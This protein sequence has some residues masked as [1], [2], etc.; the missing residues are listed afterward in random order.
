MDKKV[1]VVDLDGTLY[2]TNTFHEFLFFLVKYFFIRGAI[3]R[4]LP[5]I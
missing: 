4:L 5:L 2:N 1:L 3:F